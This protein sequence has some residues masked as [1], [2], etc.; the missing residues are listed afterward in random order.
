MVKHCSVD[1]TLA[2]MDLL[3]RVIAPVVT[4]VMDV[5]YPGTCAVCHTG[6]IGGQMLC[7]PCTAELDALTAATA[8]PK[9][10]VLLA[11]PTGP[12]PWCRGKSFIPYQKIVALGAYTEPLKTLIHQ[13]KY[14]HRW[15]MAE[16][17]AERLL[18]RE[19]IKGLLTETDLLIAVPLHWRR[20]IHRG[21][22]QAEVIAAH[23]G[24]LTGI[25]VA[26]PIKRVKATTSQTGLHS[27]A[28]RTANLRNAIAVVDPKLIRGRHIVVVD[29]VM[30][31]AAT[32]QAVGRALR[33]AEPASLCA[34]VIAVADPK[35]KDFQSI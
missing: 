19:N 17:L 28:R 26:H 23:L 22:N 20:Q 10:A 9:C 13:M 5:L 18:Q 1:A 12:C 25:K 24:N 4:S 29:D 15:P 32:L 2:A 3:R 35:R 8:C 30:T 7:R 21:Y 11:S 14:H 34:V 16:L 27:R 33:T 31:T 6:G